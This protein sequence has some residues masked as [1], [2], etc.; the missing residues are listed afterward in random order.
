MI[1]AKRGS[2]VT[3]WE[4]REKMTKPKK[5]MEWKIDKINEK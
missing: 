5:A 3:M 1:E 4:N 2:W